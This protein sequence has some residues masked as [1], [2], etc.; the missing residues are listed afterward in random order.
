MKA[1]GL[2][3]VELLIAVVI[4]GLLASLII[5]HLKGHT[6]KSRASEAKNMLGVIARAQES[7]AENNPSREFLAID[8]KSPNF[9]EPTCNETSNPGL[10]TKLGMQD[11]NAASGRYFS[12]CGDVPDTQQFIV[13][14]TRIGMTAENMATF[15][16]VA[17][18]SSIEQIQMCFNHNKKWSGN[19]PFTPENESSA[20]NPAIEPC[21]P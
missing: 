11:P 19:Y 16:G 13:K 4:I 21:C 9:T 15:I 8:T 18:A 14:A 20:C 1:K 5:P 2:S 17:Y 7:Y 12:Y 6:E 10:W 3:L